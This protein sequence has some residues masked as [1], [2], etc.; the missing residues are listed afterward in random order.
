MTQWKCSSCSYTFE[1]ET[2]PDRC[3]SCKKACTF[4]DVTCYIPECGGPQN[5]DARLM[6]KDSEDKNR[7]LK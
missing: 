5:I 6:E 3:P 1:A 4:L 7:R 2:T